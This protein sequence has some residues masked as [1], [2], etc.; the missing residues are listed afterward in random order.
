[1]DSAQRSGIPGQVVVE[2]LRRF[3][4]TA[5][6]LGMALKAIEFLGN[7]FV[8]IVEFGGGELAVRAASDE[9]LPLVDAHSAEIGAGITAAAAA[10]IEVSLVRAVIGLA[11]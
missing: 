2:F 6:D 9:E 4:E 11:G 3:K 7:V 1:M 8:Q 10:V 5:G